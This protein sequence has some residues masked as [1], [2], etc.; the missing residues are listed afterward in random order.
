MTRLVFL[1]ALIVL[2]AYFVYDPSVSHD[3]GILVHEAPL[4]KPNTTVPSFAHKE[5]LITPL[6]SFDIK[7][8]VLSKKRYRMGRE[9]E[10][11]PVDL[12]LGWGAMSDESV[13]DYFSISQSNRWYFWRYKDL[14]I[15]RQEVI[16][17]SANMHMVPANS[18]V[19][20]EL[21]R[22]KE[23][24]LVHLQG[25]LIEVTAEDG[26]RWRSSLTREDSGNH[27]CELV[28]V[29]RVEIGQTH[30]SVIE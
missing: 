5:Y 8:R 7:A 23:G 4:Q 29:E 13:L 28:W 6:A 10:L 9:A 26:W 15:P 21:K 14:P 19:A 11:S 12:A 27:A 1:A 16:Y 18:D 2:A 3:A 30:H 22:I 20:R 25:F 17:S 24:H